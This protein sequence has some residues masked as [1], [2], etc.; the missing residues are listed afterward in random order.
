MPVREDAPCWSVDNV[1][2]WDMRLLRA[3]YPVREIVDATLYLDY[4]VVLTPAE[5]LDWNLRF[6]DSFRLTH[7]PADKSDS[8]ALDELTRTLESSR[9]TL[10]WVIVEQYEWESGR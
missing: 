8:D 5:A 4:V 3:Q 7:S 2:W 9:D 6:R 1:F 10:R